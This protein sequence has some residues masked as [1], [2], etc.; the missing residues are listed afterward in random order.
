MQ[1]PPQQLQQ[2]VQLSDEEIAAYFADFTNSHFIKTLARTTLKQFFRP[3]ML[4][5]L[6]CYKLS[7]ALL[8]LLLETVD[9]YFL[10]FC[11]RFLT[12]DDFEEVI[13]ERNIS[14][15]CGYPLCSKVPTNN[16]GK[17]KIDFKSS[18]FSIVHPFL[19][20]FCSKEHAQSAT[21]YK[22]QLSDESVFLRRDICYL[23]Y[24]KSHYERQIA[25]LEELQHT[26]ATSNMSL[27]DVVMEFAN[28]S[29]NRNKT[30]SGNDA[31]NNVGVGE[32]N[33]IDGL[34]EQ[35][36]GFN[37]SIEERDPNKPSM[38]DLIGVDTDLEGDHTV[39]EG[40]RTVYNN[41]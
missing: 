40:Y 2:P 16:K 6:E 24:G 5:Q 41:S 32:S 18:Q 37:F 23:P 35:M 4:T 34:S 38:D 30:S 26:A 7:F 11:A 12:P 31:K 33:Y 25:L 36:K 27:D 22:K 29:F 3:G 39:I 17:Y 10:K 19:T 9:P 1:Q 14:H 20:K 15:T 13:D 8:P 28:M 21:F